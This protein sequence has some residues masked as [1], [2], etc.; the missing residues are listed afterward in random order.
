MTAK[1]DR[2]KELLNDPILEEAFDNVKQHLIGMFL[3]TSSEDGEAMMDIRRRIN[4]LD[5]VKADL[6]Y[7]YEE[8][9]FEDLKAAEE[10]TE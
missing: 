2:I 5:A 10:E 6:E 8:G 1:S 4:T 7:S 9:R 3:E